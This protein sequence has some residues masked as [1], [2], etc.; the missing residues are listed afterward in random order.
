[1]SSSCL[2]F[3][4]AETLVP[5]MI[6]TPQAFVCPMMALPVPLLTALQAQCTLELLFL[7][8]GLLFGALLIIAWLKDSAL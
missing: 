8:N 7:V 4:P 6:G 3:S 5:F 2:R 1:M